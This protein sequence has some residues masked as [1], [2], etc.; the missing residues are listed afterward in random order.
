MRG[1][2]TAIRFIRGSTLG[3]VWAAPLRETILD[4][5]AGPLPADIYEPPARPRGT[6]VFVHGMTFR[7]HR[8]LRQIRACRV[9]AGA[10]FRVVAPRIPDLATVRVSMDGLIQVSAALRAI[11]DRPDLCPS[12]K[13]G[14]F[15]VSY[16]AALCLL[17]AARPELEGRVAAICALGTYS[18][19]LGWVRWIVEDDAADPYARLIL[20]RNFAPAL[21]GS[22]PNI[23]AALEATI[24]DLNAGEESLRLPTVW[25][26][27]SEDERAR[28]LRL[29]DDSAYQRSLG[30]EIVA[31][32]LHEVFRSLCPADAVP[33]LR[34]PIALIHGATDHV[35]PP[36]ES[37]GLHAL[38]TASGAPSRLV[39]TTLLTHGDTQVGL[40]AL[41]D[42]YD[43]LAT[44][45][46][47]FGAIDAPTS[48]ESP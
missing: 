27:L 24:S 4:S 38:L 23:E 48:L 6:I 35:I 20:L 2:L 43:L 37:R 11:A 42:A 5:A 17:A 13:V 14:V 33:R 15:S 28:F 39:V 3:P 47:F 26:T 45:A 30:R 44:F 9:L 8:D 40:H 46:H 19:G 32:G 25:E 18:D 7:A 22:Q 29:R 10:G 31:R 36:E 34:F 16:S 41:R 1:A 12:R 21:L